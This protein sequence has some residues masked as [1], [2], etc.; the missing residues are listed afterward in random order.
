[1]LKDS[2]MPNSYWGD[3][4]LYATHIINRIPTRVLP[5]GVTPHEAY[6]GSKPSVAHLRVFGCK[7]HVHIP[8]EKRNKLDAKS[9]ECTHLG[10][11]ENRKAYRLVHR[12]SGKII[13][14]CDVV[15]HEG[16]APSRVLITDDSTSEGVSN[17]KES[18]TDSLSGDSDAPDNPPA[19]TARGRTSDRD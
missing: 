12:P 8:D 13:E 4:V 2:A 6:T 3:G 1:M 11:A 19:A 9:L 17:S 18:D 10:Y 15:F 14:S 16:S 7:A 5:D